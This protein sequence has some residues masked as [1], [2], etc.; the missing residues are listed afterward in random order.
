[1]AEIWK[2]EEDGEFKM[3][4]KR[5]EKTFK[6]LDKNGDGHIEKPEMIIFIKKMMSGQT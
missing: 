4:D 3:D 2:T 6:D 1:M 5:F